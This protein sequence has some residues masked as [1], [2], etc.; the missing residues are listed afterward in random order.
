[1]R[2]GV[3]LTTDGALS[4]L[5]SLSVVVASVFYIQDANRSR[6]ANVNMVRAANDIGFALENEGVFLSTDGARIEAALNRSA[7]PNMKA[8]LESVRHVIVNGSLVAVS[9]RTYG[10]VLDG[11]LAEA[12]FL[13]ADGSGAYVVSHVGVG[14][15]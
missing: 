11:D 1:M 14:R 9:R 4:V 2:R 5:V 7:P 3:V 15:R 10:A 12:V 13:S 8:S 6:W